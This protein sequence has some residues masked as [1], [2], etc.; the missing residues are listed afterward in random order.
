MA[1]EFYDLAALTEVDEGALKIPR[2][3]ALCVAIRRHRDTRLLKILK[4]PVA[5]AGQSEVLVLE[6]DCEGVPS[7][8]TAGI[9]YC[10]RLAL[11]VT[12]DEKNV[13]QVVALR[14]DFPVMM[15]QNQGQA[16][17]PANL[18]VYFG[19]M[20]ATLRTWTPESFLH[21]IRWW[22]EAS[23]RGE[24]HPA[25]QPVEQLF[26]NS[27]Y[28]LVLPWNVDELGSSNAHRAVI[29]RGKTRSDDTLTYFLTFVEKTAKPEAQTVAH[30][31]VTLP[32]VVHGFVER[33]PPTLGA[34]ADSLAKRGVKLA[35]LLCTALQERIGA[36]GTAAAEDDGI[37]IV[38]L[39]IPV[40]RA[41]GAAPE[42]LHRKAFGIVGGRLALGEALG[43][44]MVLDGKYYSAK[45]VLGGAAPTKWR[46]IPIEAMEVLQRNTP[47]KARVQSGIDD[48]GPRG[49]LVGVGSLGS[50]M[51]GLWGRSGWGSWTVIDNDHIKPHNL[52]RHP[53][54]GQ[55]IGDMKANVAT[56][57]HGFAMQG[58]SEVKA[59]CADACD[60]A[61][62]SVTMALESNEVVVDASTTLEYP[63]LASARDGLARH[64]SVFVTPDGNSSVMLAEDATRKQ[65]LRTLEAQYYRA[66][67]SADWGKNH[68]EG[69]LRHFW[70]GASC[71]DISLVMA[72]SRIT[73]HAATLAEQVRLILT[74]PDA[75]I[76]IW[77]RDNDT[78][79]VSLQQV[80]PFA[81]RRMELG[82]Y[83]LF[84]DN[85]LSE[86]LGNLRAAQLPV[87][88]GGILLGY[89]DLNINAVV[90]VDALAA[91]TDSKGSRESFERGIAGLR[92]AVSEATRRTAGIVG[93]VG[94]WH[95]H[96]PGHSAHPSPDDS[97]QLVYLALHMAEDGL[98]AVQLIVGEN[99]FLVRQAIVA[100]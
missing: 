31:E 50:T 59:I 29:F 19:P 100:A 26:F 36:A 62:V 4:I 87:E 28:E 71:R 81:E 27:R 99:D 83:D 37:T 63:R 74:Q 52:S 1:S 41:E 72:Y 44:Y 80:M 40:T 33:D 47:A 6:M 64:V 97:F 45:G 89:Y 5:T 61:N 92:D 66:V 30:I 82:R 34:L 14:K 60:F 39:S 18:C 46:D 75:G 24:L 70:S 51:L 67:I 96:P 79:A 57:L 93:Y 85:G 17:D 16:G 10:E 95:S 73:A 68:L 21:R 25:D 77:H 38:L 3:A 49:V 35:E 78:G 2:A 58:A 32:T 11:F 42:H 88:T 8:N 20:A 76:R 9:Q 48:Q 54:L 15:H 55:H 7:R 12:A 22:L 53:A 86:K 91:P 98:P 84:I 23:A 69:N 43:A 94:E 90:L 13:P 65:R 56:E